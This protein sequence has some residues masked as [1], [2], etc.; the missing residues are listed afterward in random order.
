MD[1][2]IYVFL[3]YG[4][5]KAAVH[6][7]EPLKISHTFSKAVGERSESLSSPNDRELSSIRNR[8]P[9]FGLESSVG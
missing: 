7:Q 9:L 8:V 4:D 3:R 2:R 6:Y 1:E 5:R